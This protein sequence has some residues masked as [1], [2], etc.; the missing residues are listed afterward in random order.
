MNKKDF[1]WKKKITLLFEFKRNQNRLT[2]EMNNRF[3]KTQ[4]H[5]NLSCPIWINNETFLKG[6]AFSGLVLLSDIKYKK[7]VN[8]HHYLTSL[9]RIFLPIKSLINTFHF[10]K[11][12]I[13]KRFHGNYFINSQVLIEIFIILLH[14]VC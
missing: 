7:P 4:Y 10:R 11:A 5:Y 3:F 12:V 1:N 13:F 9:L 6:R 14:E 2:I 8:C